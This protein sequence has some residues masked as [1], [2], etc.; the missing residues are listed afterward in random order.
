MSGSEVSP[1]T[2]DFSEHFTGKPSFHLLEIVERR[3]GRELLLTISLASNLGLLTLMTLRF[4]PSSTRCYCTNITAASFNWYWDWLRFVTPKHT[5][6][7][8]GLSMGSITR[9]SGSRGMTVGFDG[10]IRA[11]RSSQQ[12]SLLFRLEHIKAKRC[13]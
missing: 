10:V 11:L 1:S 6:K 4:T 2:C 8:Y 9:I 5:W 13:S 3:G 7:H 12:F